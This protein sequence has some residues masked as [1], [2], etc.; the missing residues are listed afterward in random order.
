MMETH[1]VQKVL[2]GYLDDARIVLHCGLHQYAGPG[3]AKPPVE[4]CER[5]AHV[6]IYTLVARQKGN[7]LQALDE[8]EAIL[9]ALCELDD[10][11]AF[12]YAP[13]LEIHT[14]KE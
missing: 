12:D 6:M 8:L 1:D 11:G 14:T 5:C 9:R 7:K 3:S 13:A 10:E 4:G 2:D